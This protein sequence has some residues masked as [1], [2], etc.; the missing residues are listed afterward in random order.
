MVF[1]G[2]TASAT[3]D[4]AS[5]WGG[6][7]YVGYSSPITLSNNGSVVFSGNTASG[8]Y[9]YGGAICGFRKNTIE[10]SNNG[11]VVFE[12]NSASGR[13]ANGGAINGETS[14]TI[15]LS[16]NGSVVFSGNTASGSYAYG[17]AIYTDGNL[18]IQNNDSVLFEK[19]AEI[20]EGTYRLRSIYAYI[21]SGNV[22]SFS[23][24][25]GKSIEFRD[26]V[27]LLDYSGSD[28]TVNLNADYGDIKQQGDIIFTGKYT[29][30]H[31]NELLDA[32]GAGRTATASEIL[33]SRTTVVNA[34]TNLYGGRL[35]VEDGAIYQGRGITAHEGSATTVMVKDAGL[36]HVGYN[37]TF[38]AGTT[39]ELVGNNVISGNVQMLEGST[40]LLNVQEPLDVTYF[41]GNMNLAGGVTLVLSNDSTWTCENGVLM[42]VSGALAGWDAEKLTV[43]GSATYGA[44]DL[45]WVDNMLV[46]NYNAETFH[47]YFNGTVTYSTRVEDKLQNFHYE[48]ILIENISSSSSG[49]AVYGPVMMAF[50]GDVTFTGN[51]ASSTGS[52]ANGGAIYWEYSSPITLSDNGS[53]EFSGNTASSGSDYANGGAICG[54]D[55]S[56]ITLSNNGSVVFERNTASGSSSACGGAIFGGVFS[57]ITLSNNGSVVFE[58]NTASGSSYANGGAIC[59]RMKSPITLS[60]NGSVVFAGNTAT[61][62]GSYASAE[63]GAV[64]TEGNLSIQ[65][66]DSVLFEKNAEIWKGTYRLRSIY[67]GG[68]GDVITLSA[69][70][71][72]SIEFRDAVYIG[73]GPTVNLNADYGDVKQL[74]DIVFTGK[75]T[76]QHLNELLE[77]AGAGRTATASEI[78]NSRTSEVYTMTN[79]YGGRL[80][81]EDG[82][83]YL[84]CGITAHEG[85]AATVR[86]KDASLIHNG[87]NLTFN[88]G[89]TLELVGNNTITGNVQMLDGSVLSFDASETNG[90]SYIYGGLTIGGALTIANVDSWSGENAL[91]MYVTGA[92]S[93]WDA[94][95]ITIQSNN[96]IFDDFTW[97]GNALVL[98][99][100]ADSFELVPNPNPYYKGYLVVR[101]RQVGDICYQSYNSVCFRDN[102]ASST[103]NSAFGGAIY[104]VDITL[105]NNGSVE[106]IGNTAS[107][108]SPGGGAISGPYGRNTITMSNNG[109][110]IFNGNTASASL[111]DADIAAGYDISQVCGGAIYHHGGS[112]TL[113]NNGSVVFEGNTA[114]TTAPSAQGFGG[115]IAGMECGITLSDNGSVIFEGNALLSSGSQRADAYGGA[116]CG[117]W[118]I[119]LSNNGRV[120]FGGNVASG[121][122]IVHGGAIF[123]ESGNLSIQNNDS[124]EFY[125]NAEVVNG[126]Y[127]LRS[128][129]ASAYHDEVSLSAAEGKSITFRDSI[130][131]G[132]GSTFK[133]NEAYEGMPQQGDIIFTGATTV[134]DLY[135]VKG[136]VAG[137]EEEIILSRTTE[138][139]V[140]TN[141]YGGRLRV[142]DGAIYMGQGITAHAGSDSTVLVK[143]ATLSHSGYDLTFNAGTTLELAGANS[144]SGNVQMLEGSTLRF[145]Y[146]ADAASSLTGSLSFEGAVTLQVA[147]YG[148]GVH[149][150]LM[151]NGSTVSG[152]DALSFTDGAGE[153]IDAADFAKVGDS[154]FY[155][156]GEAMNLTWT[157]AAGDGLWNNVSVNWEAQG[158]PQAVSVLQ[159]VIFAAGGNET[160][161]MVG[162]QLV[163]SLT[164]QQGGQYVLTGNAPG[165][166]LTVRGDVMQE[167]NSALT[168]QGNMEASA[169]NG[170]GAL[171]V[172]GALNVSGGVTAASL[173]AESLSADSLTL[174]DAT[175]T[176]T[177]SGNASLSGAVNVAGT[178]QV[179]GNLT[180]GSGSSVAN[181]TIAVGGAVT[182]NGA[183]VTSTVISGATGNISISDSRLTTSGVETTSGNVTITGTLET[184]PTA[185]EYANASEKSGGIKSF[186]TS[187]AKVGA[188]SS[189][190]TSVKVMERDGNGSQD[191]TTPLRMVIKD[192]AGNVIATSTNTVTLSN[193]KVYREFEFA[194]TLLDSAASYTFAFVD[195]TTGAVKSVS[196]QLEDQ[197]NN[198]NVELGDVTALTDKY[199]T[200]KLG[201]LVQFGYLGS[202]NQLLGATVTTG[203]GALNLSGTY[204]AAANGQATSLNSQGG[205]AT[206]S[207]SVIA[208][209]TNVAAGVLVIDGSKVLGNVHLETK[210]QNDSY[211]NVKSGSAIY[212]DG[213][214]AHDASVYVG[215]NLSIWNDGALAGNALNIANADVRVGN[216][217]NLNGEIAA[218]LTNVYAKDESGEITASYLGKVYASNKNGKR[219]VLNIAGSVIEMYGIQSSSYENWNLDGSAPGHYFDAV[220]VDGSTVTVNNRGHIKALTL[221]GDSMVSIL[222]GAYLDTTSIDGTSTLITGGASKLDEVNM[223][224]GAELCVSNTGSGVTTLANL[225]AGTTGAVK[226]DVVNATLQTPVLNERVMLGLNGGTLLIKAVDAHGTAL[227][228]STLTE[229]NP[230]VVL[231]GLNNADATEVTQISTI[232]ME[233]LNRFVSGGDAQNPDAAEVKNDG[234]ASLTV[235]GAFGADKVV[236]N[237]YKLASDE[238]NASGFIQIDGALT[239]SSNILNADAALTLAGAITGDGNV[240]SSGASISMNG[241]SSDANELTAAGKITTNAINGSHNTITAVTQV[242][243]N[244]KALTGDYNTLESTTGQVY[245]QGVL[246][247]SHNILKASAAPSASDPNALCV[248]GGVVGDY[249][250]LLTAGDNIAITSSSSAKVQGNHNTL[251]ATE[252]AILVRDILGTENRLTAGTYIS[253]SAVGSAG[254]ASNNNTLTAGSYIQASSLTGSGNTLTAETGNIELGNITGD[255]NTLEAEAGTI[256]TSTVNGTGNS[257]NGATVQVN[258]ELKGSAN[259]I[260]GNAVHV[261]T[262]TGTGHT[263]TALAGNVSIGSLNDTAQN[264][265]SAGASYG[266]T[267]GSGSA[268]NQTWTAGS[269]SVTGADGL[270]LTDSTVTI[271]GAVESAA[272]LN[273]AGETTMTAT[274]VQAGTLR[275]EGAEVMLSADR[276][277]AGEVEV[278]DRMNNTV[279]FNELVADKVTVTNTSSDYTGAVSVDAGSVIGELVAEKLQVRAG[280]ATLGSTAKQTE[281]ELQSIELQ[282]GADLVLQGQTSLGVTDTVAM[283]AGSAVQLKSGATLQNGAVSLSAAPGTAA[284]QLSSKTGGNLVDMQ[285]DTQFCIQDMLLVNTSISAAEGATVMLSGVEGS[286]N[287]HLMGGADFSLTFGNT[288]ADDEE[289]VIVYDSPVTGI[290]L[291]AGST[292][293]LA[294]DPTNNSFRDYNLVINMQGFAYDGGSLAAT[295]GIADLNASGIYL[296]GWLGELLAAQGVA[297][298][299]VGNLE[300]P[301]V[302]SGSVPM[303]SYTYSTDNNVGMIISIHGLS[304]PEPT[305]TTLSLLALTALAARRRRR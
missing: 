294:M 136:N 99:Y 126:S 222:G 28:S 140:M 189:V 284:A 142:E 273:L 7:I 21:D 98:N 100:N 239:G 228:A 271:G 200:A 146:G 26:A 29:E 282:K 8:S 134:D 208:G 81:V 244:G 163:E 129:Y 298:D 112:I 13:Y 4:D 1:E 220:N 225:N 171:S 269:L 245:V 5:A 268:S 30:T 104:G 44:S 12:G 65:N 232:R 295:G 292:L 18:S 299:G 279:E 71:G 241:L 256:T 235:R 147:G 188:G 278:H 33:H 197:R 88:S 166:T 59:G 238:G 263:I 183:A 217:T 92:V 90:T 55:S 122:S 43:T 132:S 212:I 219:G 182:M 56:P 61:S 93:G 230:H 207:S 119:V 236:I 60:D 116:I 303:V 133:L 17:G 305:T 31:L 164:V 277:V 124:V 11:S 286:E 209:G 51:T 265:I 254:T 302:P 210:G 304:V 150:L 257:L 246:T 191:T 149:E 78:L 115:A 27:S 167:E 127:R 255:S 70:A 261:G 64:Y 58:G 109:S 125:Q 15:T 120:T 190:I 173:Q 154:L 252:G 72:K 291:S 76:E 91:L 6:A 68:S 172:T 14:G 176:N 34:L 69:A 204:V 214:A 192:I 266:I 40:L 202:E 102:T 153:S 264:S 180:L 39:L 45:S 201:A 215:S 185:K 35:R 296:G 145:D 95:N 203:N 82:A 10:L 19:N 223:V 287:V 118:W 111:S 165:T 80:R 50:N 38:N 300:S 62:N 260:E 86:V 170:E 159:N 169:V 135:A 199:A 227:G 218:N 57:P 276:V 22:I 131:I 187:L 32:A 248:W 3:G 108:S 175:A 139:N 117:T 216:I 123:A 74:G 267:V 63:G 281:Q 101:E 75:Y 97:V 213:G 174:T 66:N 195:A 196:L 247:G 23:A 155:R 157:N 270:T 121:S 143:D 158:T 106:F 221:E 275:L 84:G 89:T 138:V 224:D 47:K 114:S 148:T 259:T 156:N 205:T 36:D 48:S 179:G 83:I 9:A 288:S 285:R 226:L 229:A 53:V 290:T 301:E 262:L 177:V 160:I 233:G 193:T 206:I 85:S 110:V 272:E 293:T 250:Q 289:A 24:A 181:H 258:G 52:Y 237:A 2:N 20:S 96:Y 243:T 162:N 152:W 253:A 234:I 249:N 211:I 137:T 16:N 141:L 194:P 151:L 94:N 77:S 37:L 41:I 168:L 186:T 79:L 128:I 178:L 251:E 54:V 161:T 87:Y 283:T 103:D 67:A 184:T 105:S 242:T 297:Q 113:S 280:T 144:I 46:L 231:A 49:G 240:L 107:G 25:A 42:C 130:Y 73:S 198:G 274:S